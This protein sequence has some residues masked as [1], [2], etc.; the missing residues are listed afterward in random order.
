[1]YTNILAKKK[2]RPLKWASKT[3]NGNFLENGCNDFDYISE[4]YGDSLHK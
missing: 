3:E 1:V 2:K 4:V